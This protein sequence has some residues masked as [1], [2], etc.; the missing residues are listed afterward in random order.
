MPETGKKTIKKYINVNT[1][2]RPFV[3]G[4]QPKNTD[5]MITLPVPIKNVLT[6]KLKSFNAPNSEYTFSVTE[7]NNSFQVISNGTPTTISVIPG[8]YENPQGPIPT[9]LLLDQV[10]S[11]LL[12]FD[13]SL[14]FIK[15]L[16]RYAFTGNN[17]ENIELNFD[18]NN[19]YIYNTFG[20]KLGFQHSYYSKD[21]KYAYAYPRNKCDKETPLVSGL[22]SI[23]NS[24]YY[25]ADT[26]I[27]LPNTSQYYM[28]F[29]DDFLSNVEDAFYEGCF[30]SNNNA[31]N[32]LAQIATK[33]SIDNNTFY[34]TD[35]DASFQRV[36]SGPVTLNKLHIRLFNDNEQIVDFNNNDY[37]F[38]LEIETYL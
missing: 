26:P 35:T 34:V 21:A 38:L 2:F 14:T 5:F 24:R 36:Y 9:S 20:W 30:P 32:I 31:K 4:L 33:Y 28:L 17:I 25:L 11:Q 27:T 3:K 1:K 37:N 29:V 18:V 7:V 19:N 22:V 23:G 15:E 16:Q 8:I 13:V 6:M 12:P 10:N